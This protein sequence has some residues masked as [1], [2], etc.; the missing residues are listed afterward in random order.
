MPLICACDPSTGR[1]CLLH[2]C[3]CNPATGRRCQLHAREPMA[4]P[5][6]GGPLEYYSAKDGHRRRPVAEVRDGFATGR[7][8]MQPVG[9][10]TRACSSCEFVVPA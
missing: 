2:S 6:C 8:I 5:R 4:C 1:R 10:P 7:V 9:G 3:A